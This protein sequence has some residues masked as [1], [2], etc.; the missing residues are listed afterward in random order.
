MTAQLS[1][2][3]KYGSNDDPKENSGTA[4]F[5][6]HML[7]GGSQERINF[8]E[9]IEMLGGCSIFETNPE[10]TYCAVNIFPEKLTEASKILSKLLFNSSFD[11]EKLEIERKVILNEIADI[12][13]EPASKIAEAL[14]KCLFKSHPIRRPVSGTKRTVRQETLD[15]LEGAHFSHY[16]PQNMII[17]LTGGFSDDAVE[18]VLRDFQDKENQNTILKKLHEIENGK[19]EKEAKIE[20]PGL[21]QAY[22]TI[23]AR[24]VPLKDNATSALDLLSVIIGVGESSRLF[25]ELREKRALTYDVGSAHIAGLD[26]GFFAVDCSVGPKSLEQTKALIRKELGKIKTEKINE[27]ELNKAKNQILA[28]LCR[29]FD[30][31]TELP[32]LMAETELYYGSENALLEYAKKIE[33]TTNQ[34]I[35]ETANK[36]LQ[37]NSYSTVTLTKK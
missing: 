4:H 24:T 26:F 25:V 12:A 35:I 19:P 17:V 1:V 9:K 7:V 21:D 11:K 29:D 37:D 10:F 33:A 18:R 6:E 30:S 20:K 32:R 14:A 13:D 5:L 8:H 2:M 36:Y 16:S 31:P 27:I 15:Q 3:I 28:A 22:L 23:G 34:D